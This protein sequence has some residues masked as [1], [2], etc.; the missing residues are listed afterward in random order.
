MLN[1]SL[2]KGLV[3]SAIIENGIDYPRA[4]CATL[5]KVYRNTSTTLANGE[6]LMVYYTVRTNDIL[7]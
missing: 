1:S 2:T 5:A 6:T 3:K 7:R 4:T